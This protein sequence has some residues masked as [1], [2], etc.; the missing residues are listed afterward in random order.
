MGWDADMKA[1]KLTS[2]KKYSVAGGELIL[3]GTQRMSAC[4]PTQPA[5]ILDGN[6]IVLTAYAINNSNYFKLRD[7]AA[8][9]NFGV[10]WDTGMNCI[11]MD[12][13]KG[14]ERP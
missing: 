6:K 13:N 12:T 4:S 14:Y 1:I 10:T 2:G 7:I 3:S 11:R 8:A 5:I 9:I